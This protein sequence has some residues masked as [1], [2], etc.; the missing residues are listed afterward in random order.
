M[1]NPD[2]ADSTGGG[3][4]SGTHALHDAAPSQVAIRMRQ[5]RRTRYPERIASTYHVN[6]QGVV[7]LPLSTM[8]VFRLV[9]LPARVGQALQT[10]RTS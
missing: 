3:A 6:A 5:D 10:W 8:P 4:S 7:H 1:I 2:K 9:E